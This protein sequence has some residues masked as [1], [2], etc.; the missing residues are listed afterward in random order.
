MKTKTLLIVGLIVIFFA[1]CN[2]DTINNPI[3][4]SNYTGQYQSVPYESNSQGDPTVVLL[5]AQSG[6]TV[7]GTGTW[8]G[9]TFNF[10]GTIIDNHILIN[11]K[12]DGTNLGDLNGGIDTYVGDNSSFAGGYNLFNTTY[13]LSGAIRF[14]KVNLSN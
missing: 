3:Q 9:I 8:N 14:K 10:A 1:G 6:N 12:L 4:D 7:N 2:S 5:L 13:V 11:F